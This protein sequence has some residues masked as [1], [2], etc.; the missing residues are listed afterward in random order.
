MIE[1]AIKAFFQY[2]V[3][4]Y[5]TLLDYDFFYTLQCRSQTCRSC[6]SSSMPI[7]VDRTVVPLEPSPEQHVTPASGATIIHEARHDVE[8][9]LKSKRMPVS[10][11]AVDG[12]PHVVLTIR[13]VGVW[14]RV[15][16]QPESAVAIRPG[17]PQEPPSSQGREPGGLEIAL[18]MRPPIG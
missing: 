8:W 13:G 6:G 4:F 1:F 18:A 16:Q 11:L 10:A 7:L 9:Y 12:V 14:V 15:P 5:D 2:V 3:F 17:T